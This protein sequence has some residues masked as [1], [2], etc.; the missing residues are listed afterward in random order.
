MVLIDTKVVA[1]ALRAA[2]RVAEGQLRIVLF[3]IAEDF[4]NLIAKETAAD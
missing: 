4:E 1:R 2:A 3:A